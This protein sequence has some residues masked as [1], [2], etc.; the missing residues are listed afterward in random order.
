MAELFGIVAERELSLSQRSAFLGMGEDLQEHFGSPGHAIERHAAALGLVQHHSHDDGQLLRSLEG[1][2]AASWIGRAP[3]SSNQRFEPL[4]LERDLREKSDERLAQIR[5]PFAACLVSADDDTGWLFGD[6]YGLQP[7]YYAMVND[8]LVFCSKLGPLLRAGFPGLESWS[9]DRRAVVD[10]FCFEHVTGDRTFCEGVKLLGPGEILRVRGGKLEHRSFA[11]PGPVPPSRLSLDEFTDRMHDELSLG[12]ERAVQERPRVAIT[13]S[14]GLDSRAL[15]GCLEPTER[16]IRS[17]TFGPILCRDARY[18]QRMAELAGTT[19]RHVDIDGSFLPTHLERAVETTGGMIAGTHFHILALLESLAGEADVVIDGLAGDALTGS[20]LSW[21]MFAARN[22]ESAA[23]AVFSQRATAFPDA[24]SR[25]KLLQP[26]FLH[27]LA[28]DPREAVERH[29]ENLADAP[30]WWGC[31]LFDLLERQRR[32]I[33]FGPHLFRQQIAVETP[34]YDPALTELLK[35]APPRFL[36]E[37]R[38][39]LRMHRRHFPALARVPDA[40]RSVPVSWPQ[41]ARFAKRVYDFGRRRLPAAIRPSD[42]DA[43]SSP[44]HYASWFRDSLRGFV[45]ERLLDGSAVYQ[46]VLN[47]THVERIVREHNSGEQNHSTQ[48]GCLLSFATWLGSVRSS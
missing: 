4:S 6:R 30:P 18:A 40:T 2:S 22:T 39:Y 35:Q 13:L 31:H 34:F 3:S 27:G 32:F 9:L 37:Q 10:F 36:I 48:I 21:G 12:V 16:K 11:A 8:A 7:V 17:Y 42:P 28:Y 26:D 41:S 14:G 38:A 20:H 45:E 43:G 15:L 5:S 25:A 46:D 23:S 19:H 29:F 44:T 33:Q 47:R 24:E 1:G